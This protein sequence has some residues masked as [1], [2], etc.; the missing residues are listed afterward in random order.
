MD[1]TPIRYILLE[2]HN[3][4]DRIRLNFYGDGLSSSFSMNSDQARELIES[5]QAAL[6]KISSRRVEQGGE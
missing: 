2:H 6:E 3:W 4:D 1:Y 5:I